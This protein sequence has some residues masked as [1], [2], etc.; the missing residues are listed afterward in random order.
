MSSANILQSFFCGIRGI[1]DLCFRKMGHFKASR[2][3][4]KAQR[5][6]FT[7]KTSI[8]MG[9]FDKNPGA[10]YR[11][12]YIFWAHLLAGNLTNSGSFPGLF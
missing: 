10:G 7:L 11:K 12:T 4:F 3:H 1:F 6:V 9:F 5:G 8:S 2:Y